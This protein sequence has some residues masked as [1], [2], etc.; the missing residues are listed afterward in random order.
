M[1]HGNP[2]G[3]RVGWIIAFGSDQDV[4]ELLEK[5]PFRFRSEGMFRD[6]GVDHWH[7]VKPVSSTGLGVSPAAIGWV[8]WDPPVS[9]AAF[10]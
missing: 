1:E 2:L 8:L 10:R 3:N 4:G 6:E 9:M 5:A 7:D